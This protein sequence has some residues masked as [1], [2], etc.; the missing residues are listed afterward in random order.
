M[1][2]LRME[3]KEV[4]T[5]QEHTSG[6]AAPGWPSGAD[7]KPPA[8]GPRTQATPGHK[9][10]GGGLLLTGPPE[11]R[12]TW[13][14]TQNLELAAAA[15]PTPVI[16]GRASAGG[17][18]PPHERRSDPPP[19][20]NSLNLETAAAGARTHAPPRLRS[21]G[22][23]PSLRADLP[24]PRPSSSAT[25]EISSL[26]GKRTRSPTL[27]SSLRG[28]SSSCEI[29]P[30]GRASARCNSQ[31]DGNREPAAAG[32]R[33]HV[34]LL[35][36]PTGGAPFGVA[37]S[38]KCGATSSGSRSQTRRP[39]GNARG[40]PGSRAHRRRAVI[41]GQIPRSTNPCRVAHTGTAAAGPR[42][43]AP[44]DLKST[45]GAPLPD[46]I[47]NESS[48]RIDGSGTS[49]ALRVDRAFAIAEADARVRPSLSSNSRRANGWFR[50][51]A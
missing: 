42:T 10:A 49:P 20:Y 43:Q 17:A 16:P 21:T 18:P 6:R 38:S 11:P 33:T 7:P 25:A 51:P 22:G 47:P 44:P 48:R 34:L 27:R 41:T 30:G 50:S 2:A 3:R 9:S 14:T 13:C 37:G 1:H 40:I 19:T 4:V 45:G 31:P 35:H 12:A 28:P 24:E 29:S 5:P 36:A 26:A 23:G 8:A 15:H 32:Q 39:P 46:D